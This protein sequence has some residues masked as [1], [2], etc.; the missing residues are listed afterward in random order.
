[1]P[2]VQEYR[3]S[4][5]VGEVY[6]LLQGLAVPFFHHEF[7]KQVRSLRGFEGILKEV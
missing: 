5:D 1:V 6:R 2:A 3:S 4:G 7:V